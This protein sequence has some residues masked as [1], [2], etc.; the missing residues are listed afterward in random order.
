MRPDVDVSSFNP[1]FSTKSKDNDTVPLLRPQPVGTLPAPAG[2][3]LLPDVPG[4]TETA[5]L[6]LVGTKPTEWPTGLAFFANA[7]NGD[8]EMAA[9]LVDGNDDLAAYNRAVLIGEPADWAAL[10]DRLDENSAVGVLAATVAYELGLADTPP[11]PTNVDGEIAAI[12]HAAHASAALEVDDVHRALESLARAVGA[13]REVSPLLSAAL[14]GSVAELLRD[15]LDEPGAAYQAA[16][17]AVLMLPEAADVELRSVLLMQRGLSLQLSA[18]R[19]KNQLVAAI[20]DLQEAVRALRKQTHPRAWAI[21]NQAIALAYLAMPMSED[22]DRLRPAIAVTALREVLTVLNPDESPEMWSSVQINLANA[23]VYL[24]SS[25]PIQNMMEA[26]DLYEGALQMR[27]ALGDTLGQARVLANQANA[28]AHLGEREAA[29]SRLDRSAELFTL[30]GGD[31]AAD[32]LA[33]I[34]EI[35]VELDAGETTTVRDRIPTYQPLPP[36]NTMSTFG[37]G[38]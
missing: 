8:P 17:D 37:D 9:A 38:L 26:V 19:N 31:E 3:L 10:L 2:Q 34:A 7:I 15:R 36:L 11:A 24:D 29:L 1:R 18:G 5:A 4:A 16:N 12:V 25:H 30:I 32:G 22:G 20:G 6:L 33:L 13:A 35:R 28:L 21:C 14:L 23:L 27:E